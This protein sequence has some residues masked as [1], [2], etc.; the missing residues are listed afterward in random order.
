MDFS[1][2]IYGQAT[3]PFYSQ[4]PTLTFGPY[5]KCIPMWISTMVFID[6]TYSHIIVEN[7]HLKGGPDFKLH[8]SRYV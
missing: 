3:L 1:N 8:L 6:R 5:F 4:G 2:C 7:T